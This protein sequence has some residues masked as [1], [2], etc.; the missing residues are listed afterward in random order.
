MLYW[1]KTITQAFYISS[2]P[3][4]VAP[5]RIALQEGGEEVLAI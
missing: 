3:K 4:K 2:L 1:V 5:R